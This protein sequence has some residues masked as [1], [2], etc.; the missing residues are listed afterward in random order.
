MQL[1]A[2]DRAAAREALTSTGGDLKA[3]IRQFDEPLKTESR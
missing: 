2:S 1:T 3:A